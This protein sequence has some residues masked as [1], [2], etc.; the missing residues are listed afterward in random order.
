MNA[1]CEEMVPLA[2]WGRDHWSLLLY[3]DAVLTDCAGF[4][5]G[6]DPRMR[7]NRRHFRVMSMEC[8]KPRRTNNPGNGIPMDPKYGSRLGDGSFIEGHDD[9]MC[10]QDMAEEGFFEGNPNPQPGVVLKLSSRGRLMA[11]NL[12]RHKANGGTFSNYIPE[13]A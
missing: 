4:Q 10:V 8:P 7:Q 6:F 11:D 13:A 3:I 12:R 1:A 2:R 9:W 5:V